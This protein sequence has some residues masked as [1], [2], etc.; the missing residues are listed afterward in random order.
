MH[1]GGDESIDVACD[2]QID[3]AAM[4]TRPAGEPAIHHSPI[5]GLHDLSE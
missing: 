4:Y 5:A 1:S 3:P 2:W